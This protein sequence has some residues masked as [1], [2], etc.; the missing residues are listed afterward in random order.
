MT[1]NEDEEAKCEGWAVFE[2]D[3]GK[4]YIQ[5][6][7]DMPMTMA[8]IG[9]PYHGPGTLFDNDE[10]ARSWVR[11]RANDGALHAITALTIAQPG[12]YTNP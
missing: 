5:R 11:K 6:I 10:A 7:D 3:D 2:C 1:R 4:L 12:G 8:C 9:E